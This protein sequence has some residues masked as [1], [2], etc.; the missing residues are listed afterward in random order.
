MVKKLEF[1]NYNPET[2]VQSLP[3]LQLDLFMAAP[4]LTPL[5]TVVIK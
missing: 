3:Q 1:L 5:A 2:Q 4:G